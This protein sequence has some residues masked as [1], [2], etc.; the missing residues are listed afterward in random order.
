M[1]LIFKL[2]LH[3]KLYVSL[4]IN[5]KRSFDNYCYI[6]HNII[7]RFFDDLP[8]DFPINFSINIMALTKKIVKKGNH[9]TFRYIMNVFSS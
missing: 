3:N 1:I 7:L 6:Y 9:A 5:N 2:Y 4:S 8:Q